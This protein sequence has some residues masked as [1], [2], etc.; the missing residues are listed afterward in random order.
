MTAKRW[1]VRDSEPEQA[2]RLANVLGISPILADLL[3]ARGYDE[4]FSARAFLTP[5]YEQLYYPYLIVAF[6]HT[7]HSTGQEIMAWTSS[8]LII[9]FP[10]MMKVHRRLSQCLIRIRLAASIRTRTWLVSEWHSNLCMR[11]IGSAD[12]K[13]KL[14]HFSRL[15][16]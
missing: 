3:I 1:I 4:E 16:R 8:L 2:A 6:V 10:M 9:I 12:A 13:I 15:S 7:S 14:R 5:T 11:C